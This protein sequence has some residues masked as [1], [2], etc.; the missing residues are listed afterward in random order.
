[1]VITGIHSKVL[2]KGDPCPPLAAG[3][4]RLYTMRFCPWAMRV[5]ITCAKKGIDLEV[6]NVNLMDKPEW[7]F[8]K[9]Y[10]GK[11]PCLE[12]DGK[13]VTESW[14]IV[15]YLEDRFPKNPILP[16]DP[17]E[18]ANQRVIAERNVAISTAFHSIMASFK[19]DSVR[20]EGLEKMAVAFED[21]EK[22]LNADYFAGSEPGY[23][24]YLTFAFVEKMWWCA[25]IDGY[26]AFEAEKFPCEKRYPKLTKWFA[27]M[28]AKPEIKESQID[29]NTFV[30]FLSSF[31]A[32]NP[33]YD[34]DL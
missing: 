34:I 22:L 1:M 19:D 16:S 28:L 26:K 7:Y 10:A 31:K 14:V 30:R 5:I 27:L 32:G 15:Q 12:V 13:Y 24:D 29:V 17:F 8:Q 21:A 11:V 4:I 9:H 3:Q 23:A 18:R 6:V 25:H 20:E 2:K 33:D